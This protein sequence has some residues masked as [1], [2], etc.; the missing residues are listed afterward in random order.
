MK[1]LKVDLFVGMVTAML[2]ALL[3]AP[4]VTQAQGTWTAVAS[5]STN[6]L[7][8]V[9][10][11]SA[12]DVWAVGVGPITEHWNGS[13][14]SIVSSPTVANGK[15]LGV[16]A[17]STNDVWAVGFTVIGSPPLIEH[18][19]GTSWR[20]VKAPRQAGV[21][22]AVTA[23][24]SSDVWAVGDF[25]NASGVRQTLIE[26]WNGKKWSVVPSPN[27]G[28]QPNELLGVTA[29][30]ANDIWAVGDVETVPSANFFQTL[31][32]HWDGTS[33]STVSSP[34]ISASANLRAAAA[35]STSDVWAV[36]DSGSGTLIEQ[37]NGSTWSVVTHPT[38]P[39]TIT[40][41]FNGVAIVSATEIWAV[42]DFIDNNTGA[43]Q[44]LIELWNGTSWS[45]VS[46]PNPSG[47]QDFFDAASA[48]PSSGQAWAVGSFIA[49]NP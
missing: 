13:A 3:L 4:A 34:S 5:P 21:L 36:G 31:T 44:T 37:W 16:A 25:N 24:S 47:M 18:W 28:T 40:N 8:A 17:A 12:N 26:Q 30:S 23:V 45:I 42:G 14:W 22:N 33:W 19:N 39:S 32:L 15:L 43:F 27:V 38:D 9:T 29:V 41:V 7:H 11:I 35:V 49:F 1:R 2:F 6:E 20:T 48:D 10:S 46:S